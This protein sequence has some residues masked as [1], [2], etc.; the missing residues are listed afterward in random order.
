MSSPKSSAASTRPLRTTSAIAPVAPTAERLRKPDAAPQRLGRAVR[1]TT[2]PIDRMLPRGELDRDAIRARALWTAADRV[3]EH[4]RRAAGSGIVA[5]RLDG[6]PAAA[7]GPRAPV[8]EVVERHRRAL[9]DAKDSVNPYDWH[10]IQLVVLEEHT[11]EE[12][13][14]C[15]GI[16][17]TAAARAVALDRLRRGLADLVIA[18]KLLPEGEHALSQP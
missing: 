17:N 6:T 9:Q 5:L 12:A 8:T 2:P 1:I 18:W 16:G 7:P 4:Y 10:A 3:R 11:L 15:I 14:R 13:G